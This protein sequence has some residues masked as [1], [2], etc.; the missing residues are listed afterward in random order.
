M[1]KKEAKTLIKSLYKYMYKNYQKETKKIVDDVL[2]SNHIAEV[3]PDKIPTNSRS[4]LNKKDSLK[5]PYTKTTKKKNRL[6]LKTKQEKGVN[7]SSKN[8]NKPGESH[9]G[10]YNK[11]GEKQSARRSQAETLNELKN[12][13]KPNLP[14]SEDKAKSS[15][16]K[17]FMEKRCWDGYQ[18]TPGKK[19]YS[20][21]SC[22]KK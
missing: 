5:L 19:A 16:L 7:R 10:V 20:K 2:D 12:M 21:G 1:K 13:P 8:P 4:V 22:E 3:D 15:K 11:I 17:K 6:N 9:S 18:S 14:K